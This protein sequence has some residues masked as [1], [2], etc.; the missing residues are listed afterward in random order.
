MELEEIKK[1]LTWHVLLDEEKREI[2]TWKYEGFYE[3]YNLPS[4]DELKASKACFMNPD[5]EKNFYGFVSGSKLLG[6]VRFK[7]SC[8]EVV[9]GIGLEPS[10][11]GKHIG[12]YILEK[13]LK[14]CEE[15]Y[16]GKMPSLHVRIQNERARCCY[17]KAGFVVERGEIELNNVYS[18]PGKFYK[19]VYRK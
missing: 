6:Y 13:A 14:I 19:M 16:P 15:L 8:D 10:I 9:F 3:I 11:C 17:E 2:C 7:L 5:Q 18:E 1:D 12:P 4:Y